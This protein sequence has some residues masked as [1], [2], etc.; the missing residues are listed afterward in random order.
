MVKIVRCS[1]A[2]MSPISS[3]NAHWTGPPVQIE[4]VSGDKN[5]SREFYRF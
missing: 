4:A 5:S 1:A 3:A 2:A